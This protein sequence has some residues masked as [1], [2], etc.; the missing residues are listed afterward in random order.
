MKNS[1]DTCLLTTRDVS[2]FAPRWHGTHRYDIQVLATHR[3]LHG[4]IDIL[5]CCNNPWLSVSEVTWDEYFA[6]NAHCT[7]TTDLV[8]YISTHKTTSLHRERPFSHYI[9]SHRLAAELG[10]TMKTAYWA[11][12]I[13]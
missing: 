2:M 8:C 9:H 10:T 13:F 4:C 12:K 7:L 11:E 5:H 1:I 3:P 6:R